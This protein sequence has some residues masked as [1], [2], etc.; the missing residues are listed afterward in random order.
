MINDPGLSGEYVFISIFAM[1]FGAFGAGQANSF[2]PDIGKAVTAAIKIFK[3]IDYPAEINAVD[4]P[5]DAVDV[6]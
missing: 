3:I 4:I 2:G 6:P 1:L 5:K